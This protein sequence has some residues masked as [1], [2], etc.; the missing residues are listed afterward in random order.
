MLVFP[1]V[2]GLILLS[3]EVVLLISG[4]EYIKATGSLKLLSI[5]LIFCIFG[6][7]YNQC[8]LIPARKENR[9]YSN[10]G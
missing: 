1:S 4:K 10:F 7:I 3:K 5:A 8:V 9:A 2:T 6:W